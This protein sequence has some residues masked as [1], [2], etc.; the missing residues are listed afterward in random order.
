MSQNNAA[1]FTALFSLPDADS[2]VEDLEISRSN[3]EVIYFSERN[4]R[5]GDGSI[6]KSEDAG[7]TFQKLSSPQGSTGGMRRVKAICISDTDSKVIF[8]GLRTGN[9]QNKVFKSEDGGQNWTNLTTSKISGLNI[10]DIIYQNGTEDGVYIACDGGQIFY[11][12]KN[13]T[14]WE[15]HGTGLSVSHFTRALKPF[16]KEN[17]LLSGSNLGVWEIDL[18]KVP[19]RSLS[20]VLISR[21][22]I[23][24]ETLFI[25]KIFYIISRRN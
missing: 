8:Q 13:M 6:W 24:I 9:S 4:N 21:V 3:P 22:P 20:L 16:Y 1:S 7:K 11:R 2:W 19:N 17:K 23:V 15:L 5:R 12:N 25:L 18:L 14:D 10:S